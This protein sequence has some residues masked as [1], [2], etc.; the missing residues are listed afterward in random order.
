MSKAS[1]VYENSVSGERVVVRVGVRRAGREDVAGA[2]WTMILRPESSTTGG[3]RASKRLT[4]RL[5]R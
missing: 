1:E 3:T 5:T 2:G 4:Y